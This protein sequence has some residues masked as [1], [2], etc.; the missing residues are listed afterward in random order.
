[1]GS[2]TIIEVILYLQLT[3]ETYEL[4]PNDPDFDD[5]RGEREPL[6]NTYTHQLNQSHQQLVKK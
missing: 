1:M 3:I 6:L 4:D 2:K 5:R